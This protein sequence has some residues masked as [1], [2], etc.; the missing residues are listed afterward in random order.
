MPLR[1]PAL[2]KGWVMTARMHC[3]CFRR[4]PGCSLVGCLKARRG[5]TT[6]SVV[7]NFCEAIDT[8]RD[9]NWLSSCFLSAVEKEPVVSACT[10]NAARFT[11]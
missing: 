4:R 2:S 10:A 11:R 3:V 7:R 1:S 9:L 8:S 6:V 5:C